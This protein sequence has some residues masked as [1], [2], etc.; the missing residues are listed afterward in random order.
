MVSPVLP[1]PPV[2][3]REATIVINGTAG[4]DTVVI[5]DVGDGLYAVTINGETMYVTEEQLQNMKFDLGAGSDC[6]INNTD[7]GV[8]VD[9]GEG[10]DMLVGGEGND[11]IDGGSGDDTVR[12]R[13]GNDVIRGGSGDDTLWGGNGQDFIYGGSGDDILGGVLGDDN[14]L[15]GGSGD[16]TFIVRGNTTNH[17]YGGSGDDTVVENAGEPSDDSGWTVSGPD[18]GAASVDTGQYIIT[19]SDNGVVTVTNKATGETYTVS[20]DPHVDMNGDGVTDFDFKGT[21]T[22]E[23]D[24]GT[25]I[26]M[27][28]VPW[29]DSGQTVVSTVT[30]TQGNQ[31]V[32]FTGVDPNT[33]GDLAVEYSS[34]DGAE[35]DAEVDDGMTVEENEDGSGFLTADGE[36]VTQDYV[37]GYE[38]GTPWDESRGSQGK[39]DYSDANATNGG[40]TNGER[41]YHSIETV[42]TN[43]AIDTAGDDYGNGKNTKAKGGSWWMALFAKLGEQLNNEAAILEG[44]LDSISAGNDKPGDLLLA[45][46]QMQRLGFMMSQDGAIVSSFGSGAKGLAEGAK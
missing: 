13:G 36:L 8:E 42:I 6:F 12:G 16:D 28:T 18:N 37:T 3:N 4:D 31:G 5:D 17:I 20:G 35:M 43:Q 14:Y 34:T 1:Q 2:S 11:V 26:T 10:D 40:N 15:Y 38:D 46:A 32:T 24:D 45:S 30:V 25:K 21:M 27:T 39:Q 7:I 19:C 29:G 22:I 44:Q 9:G 33:T 23:L 41:D